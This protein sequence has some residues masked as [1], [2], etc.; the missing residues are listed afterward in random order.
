VYVKQIFLGNY[1]PD[2]SAEW[3]SLEVKSTCNDF[4]NKY[5]AYDIVL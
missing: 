2:I 3:I 4:D 1:R 5:R